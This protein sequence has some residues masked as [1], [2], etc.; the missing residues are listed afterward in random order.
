V[1]D[2]PFALDKKVALV[3]GSGRGLGLE[4]A[5]G[6]AA[7][8]ARVILNGRDQS[9]LDT[10]RER[11]R[12]AGLDAD[13]AVFDVAD[14]DQATGLIDAAAETDAPIDILVNNVGQRDRRGFPDITAADLSRMLEVNLVAPYALAQS[15]ATNLIRLGRPGRIINISSIGGRLAGPTDTAYPIVKAGLESMTR[16][17]AASLGPHQITVNAV[18]PGNFATETNSE[19]VANDWY[20]EY[21][22]VRTSLGRWGRPEEIAGAAV[23]LASD[24][25]SYVTGQTIVVDGGL[26]AH[27]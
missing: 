14:T 26:T 20:R 19:L 12:A 15:A 25:A 2:Y 7:A 4:I 9:R 23:Y 24:A 16:A 11:F 18:A 21:L 13:I 6:L 27:L 1:P 5:L 22:Q 8:G 17:L 10:A 3:T